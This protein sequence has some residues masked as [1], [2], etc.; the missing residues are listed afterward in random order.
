MR[1]LIV[2]RTGEAGVRIGV[3]LASFLGIAL[4][5]LAWC[6]AGTALL[7][8]APAWLRWGLVAWREPVWPALVGLLARAALLHAHRPIFGVSPLPG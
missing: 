2:A 3:S 1:G 6:H 7:W 5:A 8:V 4:L